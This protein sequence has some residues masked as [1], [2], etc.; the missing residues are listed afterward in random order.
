M[1]NSLF[2]RYARQKR[3]ACL[4][5]ASPYNSAE[6]AVIVYDTTDESTHGQAGGVLPGPLF[7]RDYISPNSRVMRKGEKPTLIGKGRKVTGVWIK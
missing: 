5:I 4:H 6:G 3:V 7:A 1:R 2:I